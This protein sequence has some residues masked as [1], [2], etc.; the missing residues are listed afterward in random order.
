M[1]FHK[2]GQGGFVKMII[3][4]I[5][6]LIVLGYFGLNI[7]DILKSPLVQ[8]NLTYAWN[9]TTYVWQNYLKA[10][11]V[12]LWDKLIIGL[13]WNSLEKL[14]GNNKAVSPSSP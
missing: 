2:T 1:V 13:G 5:I 10:P 8:K 12:F 7:Q 3:F 4:I 14:I 9:L 6:I 11:A